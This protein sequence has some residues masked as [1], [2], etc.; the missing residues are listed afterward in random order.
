LWELKVSVRRRD[1]GKE[2]LCLNPHIGPINAVV[3]SP[4]GKQALFGGDDGTVR[5]WRLPD[6]TPA[7]EDV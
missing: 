1:D 5:L 7:K 6:A 2:L 4:D 3:F